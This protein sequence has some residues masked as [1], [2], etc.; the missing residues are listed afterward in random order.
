MS[1]L[2]L[3]PLAALL[4]AAP[5]ALAQDG[6]NGCTE[7]TPC[8][9]VFDIDENGFIGDPGEGMMFAEGDWYVVRIFNFDL[10]E[11][12][13]VTL[14]GHASWHVSSLDEFESSPFRLG[15]SGTLTLS[16]EPSGDTATIHAEP[17]DP[18]LEDDDKPKRGIPA[19]GVLVVGATVLL[20]GTVR[21][22]S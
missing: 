8:D 18:A 3:Y 21:R 20:A 11:D 10:L 6:E 19:L 1:R 14:Q 5:L 22:R 7:T 15:A 17:A 4:L 2:I 12:H 13:T 9:W 16:D